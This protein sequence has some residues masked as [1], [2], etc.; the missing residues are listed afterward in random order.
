[1]AMADGTVAAVPTET[2]LVYDGNT[3]SLLLLWLKVLGLSIITLGFYRF[4]GRTRIRTYLWSHVSLLGDRCE[5]DGTGME[6]FLR[7]VV[8]LFIV[9]P[10]LSITQLA[11]LIGL[12]LF[13][14]KVASLV[15]LALFFYLSYFAVYAGRRY[16]TSRTLWRG[17]RGGLDGSANS[18]AWRAIGYIALAALTLGFTEPWRAVGL[19]RYEMKNTGFGDVQFDFEGRGADLFG[20]FMITWALNLLALMVLVGGAFGLV[21]VSWSAQ[22]AMSYYAGGPLPTPGIGWRAFGALAALLYFGYI[23]AATL[24]YLY[25][26]AR[27]LSYSARQTSFRRVAFAADIKLGTLLW[28]QLGNL[29]IMIVTLGLG[30]PF[31][32]Q[33]YIRFFCSNL[34]LYGAEDLELL[35]QDPGRRRPKGGEGLVQ[36]LDSGGFA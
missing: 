10:L 25:F 20:A 17:I 30:T 34:R 24:A 13:W 15:Q 12:G 9:V 18:Y 21:Y 1:M 29:L 28:L 35:S 14:A 23:V 8:A 31:T 7:F 2:R 19:W 3:G 33:R 16:R 4:W 6:L 36:L 5:Y 11:A 22:G 26:S 27:S 32:A